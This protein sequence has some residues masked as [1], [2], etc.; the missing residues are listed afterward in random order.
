M[1]IFIL[2]SLHVQVGFQ[3]MHN[4][5]ADFTGQNALYLHYPVHSKSFI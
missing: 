3:A 2:V 5:P 1:I 4:D